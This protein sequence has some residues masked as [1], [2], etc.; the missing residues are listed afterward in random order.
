MYISQPEALEWKL[1]NFTKDNTRIV[2]D[3]DSTIT[4]HNGK[5]SW[6]LFSDSWLMPESYSQRRNALK[7]QYHPFEIDSMLTDDVRSEYMR[8]W[9]MKHLELLREY[10]LERDILERIVLHEM[11]IRNGFDRWLRAM[12]E[13]QIPVLILSAWITQSIETVLRWQWLLSPNIT[14]TSNLLRFDEAGICIW[15]DG[16]HIIHATNKDDAQISMELQEQWKN[17]TNIILLWDSLDDIRMIQPHERERTI[18]I[19]F[20]TSNRRHQLSE[21]YSTF[22]ITIESDTDDNGII[23]VLLSKIRNNQANR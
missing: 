15:V 2:T 7:E 10:K 11:H 20:N 6:S 3:F 14:I 8:I 16:S 5:T 21:F 13:L 22:D 19:G 23:E 12:H 17:R 4:Q 9:W 1:K 18:A